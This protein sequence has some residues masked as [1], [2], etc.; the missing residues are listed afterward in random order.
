MSN[1]KPS[2][3]VVDDEPQMVGV[4]SYAFQVAGFEPVAAYNA[5]QALEQIRNHSIDI[6]I[7]DVMM[8]GQ[9]GFELCQEI[10]RSFGL[11]VL[12][13]TAKS[14]QA[15]VITGLELGADDYMA[16]PFST[17]ELVL[18]AEAILRRASHAPKVAQSGPLQIDFARHTVTLHEQAINLSPLGYRLLTYLFNHRARVV[19]VQ[20]L[21]AEV[22]E[23]QTWEGG[24][25]MVK[26]EVYR[27]RQKIEPDPK[28]P[29][30]IRTIRS[31]GYQFLEEN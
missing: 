13:L 24:S 20:E 1:H 27:L 31:V 6:V 18:R 11:P 26:V 10:R 12:L 14:D 30:Y 3:L 17:R 9:D 7:L 15:D 21:L 4:I 16:K 23:L 25:E 29:R 5:L 2:V 8:P 22:W 28:N 19:G